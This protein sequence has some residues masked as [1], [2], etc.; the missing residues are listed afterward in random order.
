M[1]R[2]RINID[3]GIEVRDRSD[4]LEVEGKEEEG[5]NRSGI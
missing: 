2:S 1:E 3:L 5:I 4:I